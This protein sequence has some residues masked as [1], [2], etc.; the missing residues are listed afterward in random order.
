[1]V[2]DDRNLRRRLG[3]VVINIDGGGYRRPEDAVDALLGVMASEWPVH[4]AELVSWLV[5]AGVLDRVSAAVD[6]FH[7]EWADRDRNDWFDRV[8]TARARIADEVLAL[9]AHRRED[10]DGLG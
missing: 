9:F 1:M 3:L 6:G 10:T 8:S 5:D 7:D 2:T 4:R